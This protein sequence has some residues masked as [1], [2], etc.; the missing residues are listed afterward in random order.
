[1]FNRFDKDGDG[2]L[3]MND[4]MLMFE[5]LGNP[6]TSLESMDMLCFFDQSNDEKMSFE[7]FVKIMLYKPDDKNVDE[8]YEH[9]NPPKKSV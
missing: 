8:I 1:M 2:E 3:D 7:E 5:E 4:L 9:Y 6:I